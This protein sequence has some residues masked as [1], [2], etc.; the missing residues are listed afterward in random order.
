MK[1]CRECE[2]EKPLSEYYQHPQMKD[3]HLNKCKSCVKNRVKRYGET[4]ELARKDVREKRSL[5]VAVCQKCG[6]QFAFIKKK[7]APRKFCSRKCSA[8]YIKGVE[9][10]KRKSQNKLRYVHKFPEKQSAHDAVKYAL[11]QGR[12]IKQ[13]CEICGTESNVQAHHDDYSKPLDIR[14]LCQRHHAD[15]HRLLKSKVSS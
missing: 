6:I 12:I 15:H 7:E 11:K 10:P 9:A 8:Q 2:Y 5:P 3:G 4:P 14:W 13:P 1:T